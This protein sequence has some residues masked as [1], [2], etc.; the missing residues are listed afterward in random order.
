VEACH[1][2]LGS[3]LL[4]SEPRQS[5]GTLQGSRLQ[6]WDW[7]PSKLRN[8]RAVKIQIPWKVLFSTV[9]GTVIEDN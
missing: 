3:E 9:V 1:A 7:V 4:P 5:V 2:A 8:S 6:P